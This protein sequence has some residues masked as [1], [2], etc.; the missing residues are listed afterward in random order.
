M[1]LSLAAAERSP[2]MEASI[3]YGGVVRRMIMK[4]YQYLMDESDAPFR[5]DEIRITVDNIQCEG[6]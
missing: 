5:E 1:I 4:N 2:L 3:I 6:G